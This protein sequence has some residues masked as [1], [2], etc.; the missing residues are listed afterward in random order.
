MKRIL[1]VAVVVAYCAIVGRAA[2][3]EFVWDDVAEIQHA[4][5]FDQDLA[6]VLSATQAQ[7]VDPELA[8]NVQLAYDSY[9]PLT[10]LSFWLEIRAWGRTPGPMHVTNLVLG[11]LA[12]LLVYGIAAQLAA[13][14]RALAITA[15]FALHPL[16][17][18]TVAYISAR[19]DVLAGTLALL[20][21][22][23]ALR[24]LRAERAAGWAALA[25]IAFALCLTAKETC[26]ALPVGIL[27]LG[28]CIEA[29]RRRLL[30]LAGGLFGL[31]IAW[32]AIRGAVIETSAELR[33]VDAVGRAPGVLA[34]YART[35]I[36]PHDLSIERL[37]DPLYTIA[38]CLAGV[39]L[40]LAFVKVRRAGA[41]PRARLAIAGLVWF[42]VMLGPAAIAIGST[43]VVSDRY[44]YV[45]LLGLAIALVEAVAALL[46]ARPALTRAV[47]IGVG[48]WA[49]VLLVIAWLQIG[50][51]HDNRALYTT[52]AVRSPHSAWA[53]QRLGN[54]YMQDGRLADAMAEY[55]AAAE[56]EPRNWRALN[57]IGTL[58]LRA[59]S[60]ADAEE[61]LARAVAE[62]PRPSSYR[63]RF[64]L[65]VARLGAGKRTEG[66]ASIAEALAIRPS[67][68]QAAAE[69]ARSCR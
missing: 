39:L 69:Y 17:I 54:V 7:R 5:I 40:A 67:Y 53:H 41:L 8:S 31:S 35:T 37:Y 57:N 47:Q 10:M 18:E 4:P 68:Q 58:L 20:A 33:A 24:A 25:A 51:W 19:G 27:A 45:A 44:G 60:Y 50:V 3:F 12:I 1:V 63:A 9:R 6:T 43:N 23:A 42:A 64:N 14:W 16:Q 38:G 46:R 22:Y 29:P 66:C 11:L 30:A 21:T 2:G 49:A 65:G 34:H 61:V 56:I 28:W 15:V 62:A 36:A 26:I 13:D 48:L 55:V 52:A 32:L 59:R